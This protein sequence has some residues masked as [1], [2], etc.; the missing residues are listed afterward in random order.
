[1]MEV[2]TEDARNA[3]LRRI[4]YEDDLVLMSESTKNLQRKFSLWKAALEMEEMK[5]ND[6]K[7]KLMMN[8]IE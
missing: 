8:G 6:N 2:V 3:V 1:M 4:L 5:V 7:T